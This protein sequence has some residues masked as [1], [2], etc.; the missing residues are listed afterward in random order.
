MLFYICFIEV[1]ALRSSMP[2]LYAYSCRIF[3]ASIGFTW[4]CCVVRDFL[5][6]FFLP[7]LP[8]SPSSFHL[9]S[10]RL[11]WGLGLASFGSAW[12]Y[13]A[14]LGSAS[15]G[16]LRFGFTQLSLA[17]L[18]SASFGPVWFPLASLGFP[19]LEEA[20]TATPTTCVRRLGP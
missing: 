6:S 8:S 18:H 13:S 4:L 16:F 7:F 12:L 9:P 5:P 19:W 3:L 1:S 2:C 20:R 14:Q 15:L 11:A 17:R 10:F